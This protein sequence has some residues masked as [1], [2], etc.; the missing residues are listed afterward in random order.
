M[1][2]AA[3][4]WIPTLVPKGYDVYNDYHRY[5]LVHGSRKSSKTINNLHKLCR[6]AFETQGAVV[7]FINKTVKN[8]KSAGVWNDLV[9]SIVPQWIAANIGFRFAVEP[10][11]EADTKLNRFTIIN[12]F[13]GE[14]EFQL[15]SLEHAREA[16]AKFKGTRFSMVYLSEADQFED[17]C[18]FEIL[19]TQLRI[20]SLPYEQHQLIADTNPPEDGTDHWLYDVFFTQPETAAKEYQELFR[21]IHFCLDDNPFLDP[22]EKAE[23]K[24]LYRYDKVKTARFVDGLWEKDVSGTLF[25]DTFRPNFHIQGDASAQDEDDWEVIAP[26]KTCT[27]L[28]GGFD[29][30]DVHSAAVIC[31]KRD[32]GEKSAF[33][34]ID[35]LVVLDEKMSTA[36]FTELFLEKMDYWE[37]FVKVNYGT[38]IIRWRHWS[39]ASAFNFRAA[40]NS[41]EEL[42]VRQVSNGRIALAGVL[43]LA[44]SVSQGVSL[45]RKLLFEERLFVSDSC[46]YTKKMLRLLRKGKHQAVNPFMEERH[47]FDAL[48]YLLSQ[49]APQDVE[50]RILPSVAPRLVSVAA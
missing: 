3:G 31:T 29:L 11:M 1:K 40:A 30:G 26:G 34:V 6:H 20:L 15:H 28:Y 9:S 44:G 5:L 37:D 38:Q 36:R 7:G 21:T 46:H 48:R 50:S 10:R 13:G 12:A 2:D 19:C 43:K 18:V 25:E 32:I 27:M 45:V 23:L 14:S 24:H 16:E 4:N 49:E 8:A 41:H 42:I 17:R 33:D 22:R 47:V 39:D 35:E